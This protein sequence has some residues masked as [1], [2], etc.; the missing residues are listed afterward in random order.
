MPSCIE[1][2]VQKKV[3]TQRVESGAR[4]KAHCS[5]KPSNQVDS[6]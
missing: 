3:P 4:E 2:L 1:L 6:I 5:V